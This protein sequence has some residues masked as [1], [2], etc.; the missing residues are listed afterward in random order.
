MDDEVE[1][2]P[3]ILLLQLS[4]DME[5]IESDD[6]E[7]DDPL[8]TPQILKKIYEK[9][10]AAQKHNR[11][12]EQ[13]ISNMEKRQDTVLRDIKNQ[14][15]I[16]GEVQKMNLTAMEK[17]K[18]QMTEFGEIQKNELQNIRNQMKEVEGG[19]KASSRRNSDLDGGD[20]DEMAGSSM[21]S[22]DG[23]KCIFCDASSHSSDDCHVVPNWMDRR[24]KV[25]DQ[26]LCLTCLEPAHSDD[27]ECPRGSIDCPNCTDRFIGEKTVLTRHHP[28]LCF[29][30]T[31]VTARKSKR[32]CLP[33]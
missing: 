26:Q 4:R 15:R 1:R 23:R 13:R 27:E 20:T 11:F 33:Y 10:S 29:F 16:L 8:S 9:M 18:T 25:S 28:L 32:R 2:K 19:W 24:C 3:D 17:L 30:G 5:E 14:M 6:V 31:P 22:S 12:L 7:F 21:Q